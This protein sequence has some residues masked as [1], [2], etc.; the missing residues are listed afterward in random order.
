VTTQGD[1]SLETR[2][3]ID[4]MKAQHHWMKGGAAI[5][6]AAAVLG[7]LTGCTTT[8]G[9]APSPLVGS[10]VLTVSMDEK[11]FDVTVVVNPDL[12]GTAEWEWTEGTSELEN[13][14]SEGNNA[15][16]GCPEI[17]GLVFTGSIDGDTIEGDVDSDYGAG[18][19]SGV[20][21]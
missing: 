9:S 20:R 19:F 16:F 13:V 5:I 17:I 6:L 4:F 1:Y 15:S 11:D 10:W 12:T 8:G 3:E 7:T 2:K 18:T 14:V 21:N